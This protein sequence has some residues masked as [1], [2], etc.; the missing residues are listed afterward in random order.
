MSTN[1]NF[2][3]ERRTKVVSNRGPSAYQPTALPLGQ[4]GS[5]HVCVMMMMMMSWCL[6]SSDVSWHIRDKL[7]PM[8]K[9]GSIILYVHGNQKARYSP[10]RP[11][12]LSHSSWTMW[13]LYERE[14]CLSNGE[15][16]PE[17]YWRGPT[18]QV[19]C[20]CM[21]IE[22]GGGGG[23]GCVCGGSTVLNATLSPK[24]AVLMFHS[25]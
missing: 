20:V 23:G 17:G 13:C 3:R 2:W 18:Y 6:M 11:P 12:R 19:M 10:G 9:P 25:L 15:F 16:S 14:T 1:H 4:T 22:A 7:W 24:R 5:Q 8:P 21:G